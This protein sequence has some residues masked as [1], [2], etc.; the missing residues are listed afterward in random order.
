M[1]RRCANHLPRRLG[2]FTLNLTMG[3]ATLVV[4]RE[5][6]RRRRRCWRAAAENNFRANRKPTTTSNTPPT[7]MIT[8][9]PKLMRYL[10]QSA[11]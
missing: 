4:T 7:A 2:V 1:V 6:L 10:W 5:W 3:R 8:S 11:H 9:S